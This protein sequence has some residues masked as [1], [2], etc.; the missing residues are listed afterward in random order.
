[1]AQLALDDEVLPETASPRWFDQLVEVQ[2][3]FGVTAASSESA[4]VGRT[5]VRLVL[6]LAVPGGGRRSR[7][8]QL[9][10]A[11][12]YSMLHQLEKARALTRLL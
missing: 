5:F 6:Q 9:S 12:F 1:V 2:W 10:V 7:R 4:R 8:V 11:Q 3:S